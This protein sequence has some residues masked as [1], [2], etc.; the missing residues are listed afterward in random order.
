MTCASHLGMR[1]V[2]VAIVYRLNL[3]PSI[4]T[5]GVSDLF[6]EAASKLCEEVT[7]L[8]G[9]CLCVEVQLGDLAGEQRLPLGI[10][11]RDVAFGV[12]DL[13]RDAK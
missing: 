3:L 1:E 5:L 13:P 4:A 10:E 12:L 2:A 6:A 7:V 9:G 11:R 8:T